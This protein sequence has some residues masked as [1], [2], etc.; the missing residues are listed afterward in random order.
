MRVTSWCDGGGTERVVDMV[1][2]VEA[3]VDADVR[4]QRQREGGGRESQ[5]RRR[6][7]HLRE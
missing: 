5:V 3:A 2:T 6:P 7:D 4:A 1:R